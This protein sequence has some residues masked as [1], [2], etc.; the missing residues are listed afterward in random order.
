MPSVVSLPGNVCPSLGFRTVLLDIVALCV[1]LLSNKQKPYFDHNHDDWSRRP[2]TNDKSQVPTTTTD[3]YTIEV[4]SMHSI[5]WISQ[6]VLYTVLVSSITS[7]IQSAM[8][9]DASCS[10]RPCNCP[11]SREGGFGIPP[12]AAYNN[13][14]SLNSVERFSKS[15]VE[16]TGDEVSKKLTS[17]ATKKQAVAIVPIKRNVTFLYGIFS[18]LDEENSTDPTEHKVRRDAQRT[19]ILT[20][21][22][23]DKLCSLQHYTE[24]IDRGEV[25]SCRIL[26]TFVV[27]AKSS[28][29]LPPEHLPNNTSPIAGLSSETIISDEPDVVH[30]NIRENMNNGKTPT[31]FK[32]AAGLVEKYDIDYVGKGDSDTMMW[33]PHLLTM[34]E[35]DLPP[36]PVA[37]EDDN[38]RIY[39]G[40]MVDINICGFNEFSKKEYCKQLRGKVYMSGQFFFV[41]SDLV[42]FL[43]DERIDRSIP[44]KHEDFDMGMRILSNPLPIKLIPLTGYQI[45]RH[46][47]AYK[48]LAQWMTTF[49]GFGR[50]G[51]P[52]KAEFWWPKL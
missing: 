28:P 39:S 3:T 27:G 25:T 32:Y 40:W 12:D 52:I 4:I 36:R 13:S 5:R 44:V 11:P 31:W 49:N 10:C 26:Y 21:L 20:S 45:W 7:T 48:K 38:R 22:P 8:T 33:F 24:A 2:S 41:S 50:K 6:M 16:Q 37:R 18:M 17:S 35:R 51:P 42:T 1:L 34:M 46:E 9:G 23:N 43:T 15:V 47:A 30:L 19:T 29:Q 14:I